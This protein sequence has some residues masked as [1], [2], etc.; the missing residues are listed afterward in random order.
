MLEK[1]MEYLQRRSLSF[2]LLLLLKTV[3]AVIKADGAR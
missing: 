1:D 3:I 2:D